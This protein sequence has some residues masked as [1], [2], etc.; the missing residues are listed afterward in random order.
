VKRRISKGWRQEVQLTHGNM[1]HLGKVS[2]S[3]VLVHCSL[4]DAKGS[5]DR[6]T[7]SAIHGVSS[8]VLVNQIHC[9]D[10]SS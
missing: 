6:D 1:V 2:F 8:Q 7:K 4:G 5:S 3:V 9:R 10:N